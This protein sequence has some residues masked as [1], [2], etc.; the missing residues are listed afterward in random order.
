MQL[1]ARAV[2]NAT[3]AN[4]QRGED[5]LSGRDVRIGE[6]ECELVADGSDERAAIRIKS[7]FIVR[8]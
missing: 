2:S 7:E 4:F 3:A 6:A 1:V 5:F 8:V